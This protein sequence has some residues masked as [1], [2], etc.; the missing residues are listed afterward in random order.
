MN[1]S[2][3]KR[4][5]DACRRY[6]DPERALREQIV[7]ELDGCGELTTGQLASN[8]REPFDDVFCACVTLQNRGR[9]FSHMGYW[10]LAENE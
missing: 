9:I 1:E 5:D 6:I 7:E 8:M 10:D 4:L 2:E 3:A